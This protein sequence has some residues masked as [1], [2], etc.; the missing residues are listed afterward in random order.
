M[1]TRTVTLHLRRLG[2]LR[3]LVGSFEPFQVACHFRLSFG[4]IWRLCC[5]LFVSR[6]ASSSPGE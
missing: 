2:Q 1:E 5:L 6:C 4:D 3:G